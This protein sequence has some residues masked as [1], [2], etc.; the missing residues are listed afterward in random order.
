MERK[1]LI[2]IDND[3]KERAEEDG[4]NAQ[5]ALH[6]GTNLPDD[7]VGTMEIIHEFKFMEDE[8]KAKLLFNPANAIVTYSMYTW[9][10]YGS[11]YQLTG[12]LEK[13]GQMGI[14]GIVYIDTSG[15]IKEALTD[16]LRFGH[17]VDLT[18][19]EIAERDAIHTAVENNYIISF[20]EGDMESFRLRVNDEGDDMFKEEETDLDALTKV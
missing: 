13:A 15:R 10:H 2:F 11:L 12:F 17:A 1:K 14:K 19:S 6:Y 7:Y 5:M 9:N 8:D 20:D 3:F 4:R 18:D 16:E